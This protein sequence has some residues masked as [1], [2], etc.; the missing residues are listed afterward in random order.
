[1]K[2]KVLQCVVH[3]AGYLA[4]SMKNPSVRQRYVAILSEWRG[5]PIPGRSY[6]FE[7]DA[8]GNFGFFEIQEQEAGGV[9]NFVGESAG[10]EDA[11]F[12]KGDVGAGGGH[13]GEHVAQGVGAEFFGEAERVNAGALGLRHLGAFGGANERMQVEAAE[14]NRRF[15]IALTARVGVTLGVLETISAQWEGHHDHASVPEE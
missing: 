14:G 3:L 4:K 2:S 1:M 13:A 8:S 15:R 10:A 11:V 5:H 9:P 12:A 6:F 7:R